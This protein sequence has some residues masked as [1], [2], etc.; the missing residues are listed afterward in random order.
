MSWYK[1]NHNVRV[2]TSFLERIVL[3]LFILSTFLFL[4]ELYNPYIFFESI[5]LKLCIGFLEGAVVFM[6]ISRIAF[7]KTLSESMDDLV[8]VNDDI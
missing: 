4:A 5:F 2:V 3:C 7:M 1:V 8:Y 6:F